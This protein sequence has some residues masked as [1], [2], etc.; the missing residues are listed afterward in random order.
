MWIFD[1]NLPGWPIASPRLKLPSGV[2]VRLRDLR[3]ADGPDWC[4][5]RIADES[6]LRPVEPTLSSDWRDGHTAAMW[7]YN[8]KQLSDAARTG[9]LFPAA[10]EADGQFVGQLTLGN[11]QHG[12]VSS[13]W[14]GYWVYS[15]FSGHGIATAATALGVDHAMRRLSLH[16][17]E[18]T[19][20]ED[21]VA[22]QQVLK[23]TGFRTEGFL[24]RN[25]H[26]NGRWQDHLLVAQT[27]EDVNLH[28]PEPGGAVGVTGRLAREGRFKIIG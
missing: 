6:Y 12:A 8:Y 27:I 21:N 25:L 14:I 2:E 10:I 20:M 28:M 4:T 26:I 11:I 15:G 7:R 13:C 19:V 22:S 9:Q 18:A 5:M 23:N 1:L 24:K 16:R 3:R 17:V